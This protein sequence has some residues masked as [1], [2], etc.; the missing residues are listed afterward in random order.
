MVGF[1]SV[2][3]V[4]SPKSH[5][6]VSVSPSGSLAVAVKA[7]GTPTRTF[8]VGFRAAVTV[9]AWLALTTTL[10]V[11]ASRPAGSLTV[12]LTA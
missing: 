10:S 2:D 9:G 3:V 11:A 4:P 1:C 7:I 8:P 6:Y 5:A 12:T